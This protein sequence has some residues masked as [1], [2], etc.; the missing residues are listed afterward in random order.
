MRV[1]AVPSKRGMSG[2]RLPEQPE[3]YYKTA[4]ELKGAL[5][6]LSQREQELEQ[7]ND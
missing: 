5:E 4:M 1:N 6:E 3:D 2:S 7:L